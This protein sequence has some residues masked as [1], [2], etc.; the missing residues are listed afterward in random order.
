MLPVAQRSPE[1]GCFAALGTP[2]GVL[3]IQLP[4]R[5]RG[6]ARC[7]SP[8]G[9]SPPPRSVASH[10]ERVRQPPPSI[11]GPTS[12]RRFLPSPAA[13]RSQL[14][15]P[16]LHPGSA[17]NRLP[18]PPTSRSQP[19]PPSGHPA[20]LQPSPQPPKGPRRPTGTSP[21]PRGGGRHRTT[22]GKPVLVPQ[23][24]R[25]QT[26]G[27]PPVPSL[28][29]VPL[30]LPRQA[31]GGGA[32]SPV[33]STRPR[34][35]KQRHGPVPAF[36]PGT[37]RGPAPSNWPGCKIVVSPGV[38]A[39]W[40]PPRP[41]GPGAPLPELGCPSKRK[42]SGISSVWPSLIR[43]RPL[44][45]HPK[46]TAWPLASSRSRLGPTRM[47][48]TQT[49]HMDLP[50]PSETH[51]TSS[52]PKPAPLMSFPAPT[53]HQAREIHQHGVPRPLR[54]AFAVG[55][56]LTVCSPPDPAGLF[57]PAAL[58]GF[59]EPLASGPATPERDGEPACELPFDSCSAPD[60]GRVRLPG[61]VIR[62]SK[63]RHLLRRD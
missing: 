14:Q 11:P 31:G 28:P 5:H 51:L 17:L 20:Q 57:H 50:S 42:R 39:R 58:M 8:V 44:N 26:H 4:N 7:S 9:W 10:I 55:P 30:P 27:K 3:R 24:G 35:R 63:E 45:R 32:A 56:A 29:R 19:S 53:A 40:V 49:S 46:V 54:S 25:A 61:R 41:E 13:S 15:S 37:P 52:R 59:Y 12:R 6:Q 16:G 38:C 33:P 22:T 62:F 23:Q 60:R 21:V 43:L 36:L 48:R 1:G 34:H 2:E 47:G 18:S